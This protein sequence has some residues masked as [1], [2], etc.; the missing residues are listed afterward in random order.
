MEYKEQRRCR[1]CNS[2][3]FEEVINLGPIYPSNFVEETEG[4]ERVPLVLVRCNY[5]GLVQLKHTVN[6]DSMYRKYYYKSGLNPSMVNSLK[7]IVDKAKRL[8]SLEEN[9]VVLDIGCN[10]GTLFKLFN[11]P[12][13]VYFGFDPALNLADDARE[14]S[15]VFINDYFDLTQYW[16]MVPKA[17]VITSIAMFYDL[18]D[19]A[20]FVHDVK[21]VLRA[22]GIWIIQFTDLKSMLEINAFDNICHEHLE[23]YSLSNIMW[24]LDQFD[25]EVIDLEHNKVN[26]GSI[27]LVVSHISSRSPAPIVKYTLDQEREFLSEQNNPFEK[28]RNNVLSIRENVMF[29]LQRLWYEGKPVY[30]L[31]ASTKGNT[32]L[33]YFG[34]GNGKYV[35]KIAEINKDKWGL[36]TIGTNIPIIP[37]TQAIVEK[38]FAFLVLPW[39]FIDTFTTKDRELV[40][41]LNNGGSMIAPMPSPMSYFKNDGKLDSFPLQF[42]EYIRK[43]GDITEWKLI[44]HYREVIRD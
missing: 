41:Y 13:L 6:L 30:G 21:S 24:L 2:D 32:L 44:P 39:H 25:L 17:K 31:G 19:P 38:P 28:F 4:F 8:V 43:E 35:E 14:N 16:G 3:M 37:Q 10:D 40:E 18:P 9:D 15:T 26:G 33:Q 5:C 27:Q 29:Y 22:D 7:E 12:K 23:Y 36:K 34:I 42:L 20:K 1:M 11:D